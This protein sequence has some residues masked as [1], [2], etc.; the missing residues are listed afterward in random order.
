MGKEK[1]P[2]QVP[3][4]PSFSVTDFFEKQGSKTVF[5]VLAFLGIIAFIVFK[6]FIFLK[7]I[8]LHKDIASDS[9][10]ASWPFMMHTLDYMK[11][12][13]FPTW[14]FNFGMGQNMSTFGFYDPLDAVLYLFSKP[15]IMKLLVWKEIFKIIVS[16]VLFYKF[17]KLLNLNNFSALIGGLLYACSGYMVVGSA[18]FI[19]SFEAFVLALLLWSFE[20]YFT[21]NKWYWLPLP[22]FLIGV[23][24]PFNF[25][26]FGLFLLVYIILRIYQSGMK[27]DT[28]T[29]GTFFL[30]LAG[31][32]VLGIGLSA[33]L[34][35][36][37]VQAMIDS[38]RGSGPDSFF[39]TL[40]SGPMFKTADKN[41]FGTSMMRLFSSDMLHAGNAFRGWGNYLEAPIFYCG[42]I[43]LLLFPQVFQF[44]D[45]TVKRVFAIVLAIWILPIIFPYFRQAIWIFS[46]DYYRGYS[47][48]VS[49]TFILFGLTAL[50]HILTKSKI[51]IPLLF[52]SLGVLLVLLNY[53]YFVDK[54]SVDQKIYFITSILLI[55]YTLLFWAIGKK[56]DNQSYKFVL[57]ALVSF[58]LC[59]FSWY[60]VNNQR[61]HLSRTE[62]K[63]DY[64]YNDKSKDAVAFIKSQDKSPFYRIDKSFTSSPTIHWGLNDAL[65]F[66]YFGTACYNSFNQKNYINYFK[67]SN[68]ISQV[69]ESESRW[70]P[71]LINHFILEALNGVKYLIT[72]DRS[73]PAW[74]NAFDSLAKFG[75]ILV[76]KS[77]N[78]LPIG[79]AY[80]K[81]VKL[82]DFALLSPLQKQVI[83]TKA[84]ILKDEDVSKFPAL[85]AYN[86]K[87]TVPANL[88]TFDLLKANFD[89]L[90]TTTFNISSFKQTHFKGEI[91]LKK[92]EMVYFSIPLDE[93]WHVSENGQELEKVI[94]TNGMTGLYLPAG[95][96]NIEFQ[97][98][99]HNLKRGLVITIVSILIFIGLLG[100]AKFKKPTI[101]P[102]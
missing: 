51:N 78:A 75:D 33:P 65:V 14:S 38:P 34:F 54:S 7:K 93:G 101:Q 79:F 81:Y 39:A 99:A 1:D 25:W 15:M 13:G 30:K 27:R 62:T 36:D 12:N 50:H 26:L 18:W 60:T 100:Y 72:K 10:N 85:S 80:S 55:L 69:N 71:G 35:L 89:S 53:P 74:Q 66:N 45:K 16:G 6:D 98:V 24:R 21:K 73:N 5:W 64:G 44:L 11:E 31:L 52:I 86:P 57:L 91:D 2:K 19:F 61:S 90:R 48:F 43:S 3:L 37:H 46:G 17:L 4:N 42:I 84:C 68:I 40:S 29:L 23:S 58:E 87:D 76:L 22:V 88:L 59:Y 9:L 82:S 77:K 96:H 97:Y 56:A 102:E 20:Q 32:V 8:Y 67:T 94:L 83:S 28:K 95:K 47:I 70:A 41:Q 92:T 63:A 49:I